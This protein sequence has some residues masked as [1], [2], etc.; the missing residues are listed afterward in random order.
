MAS[1]G[2]TAPGTGGLL[3]TGSIFWSNTGNITAVDASYATATGAGSA[4]TWGLRAYNFNFTADG[5]PDD[6]V[7]DGI[8]TMRRVK[9]NTSCADES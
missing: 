2:P 5:I 1:E 4:N 7:V 6:A 9:G 3:T 8:Q